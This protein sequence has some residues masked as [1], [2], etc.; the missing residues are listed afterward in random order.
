MQVKMSVYTTYLRAVGL[1][2]TLAVIILALGNKSLDL[3]AGYWLA[4]WSDQQ[5]G[6][7]VRY[8]THGMNVSANAT[9]YTGSNVSFAQPSV[10]N[11]GGTDLTLNLVVYAT[12]GT[13]H[14]EEI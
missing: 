5:Q 14:G 9:T 13:L 4:H 2:F 6:E 10:G 3:A 7:T 12:L 11:S 8:R 1:P